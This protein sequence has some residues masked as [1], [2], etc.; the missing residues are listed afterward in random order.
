MLSLNDVVNLHY[1][2]VD[3]LHKFWNYLW[4]ASAGAI[5]IGVNFKSTSEYLLTGYL[6]F[7]AAN[8]WLVYSTQTEARLSAT[9]IHALTRQASQQL[10]EVSESLNHIHPWPPTLVVALHGS[11]VSFV[12]WILLKQIR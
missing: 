4:L 6:P 2:Q 11:A 3:L 9:A 1:K 8:L 12:I 10:P 7:A 5:T